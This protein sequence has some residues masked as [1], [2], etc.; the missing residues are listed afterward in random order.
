MAKSNK[1]EDADKTG[2]KVRGVPFKPG[3]EWNGNAKGR[4]KG[5]R[6]KLC[7]R[8]IEDLRTVWDEMNEQGRGKG[9]EALRALAAERPDAFVKA[10]GNL[11]PREFD[12][13]ERT[14]GG[15]RS[16]WEL[17]I[18]GKL[19]APPMEDDDDEA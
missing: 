4:P 16:V 11:V 2:K 12:L 3:A 9:I 7:K 18:T 8:F 10:V 13:G 5:S 14:S 19:P 17:L 15:F 1:R 6:N